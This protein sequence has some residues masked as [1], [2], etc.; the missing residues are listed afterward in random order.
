MTAVKIL[1]QWHKKTCL[2]YLKVSEVA[3]MLLYTKEGVYTMHKYGEMEVYLHIFLIWALKGVSCQLQTTG[4][5]PPPPTPPP[6]M[7]EPWYPLYMRL[8]GRHSIVNCS[9]LNSVLLMKY[10]IKSDMFHT[11]HI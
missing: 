7:K 9:R 8:A 11:A 6:P 2:N 5:L 3:Q 4:V 10:I 1:Y